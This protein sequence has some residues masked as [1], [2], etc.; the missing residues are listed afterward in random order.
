MKI[1]VFDSGLGGLFIL[2]SIIKKLPCCDYVYLGD[3]KRL[4][5]G[6]RSKETVQRFVLEAVDFLFQKD[7]ALIILACNTASAEALRRIQKEYLPKKYP[8]RRVLGVIIPTVE[9][10]IKSGALKVGVLATEGTVVSGAY[11]KEFKKRSSGR[12]LVHQKAAPLLVPLVE[13]GGTKHSDGIIEEYLIPL[14][15]KKIEALVLGC[16]HYPVLKHNIRKFFPRKAIISQDSIIADK[17]KDYLKRHPEIEKMISNRK[18]AS[19][20]VTEKTVGFE[21]TARKWFGKKIV[22]RKAVLEKS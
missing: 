5:Y 17:L 16:T 8:N 19:F 4:P 1:G 22:L 10:A 3:T 2:K 18:K 9:E 14:T 13:Y 11:V 15:N 7:C 12:V 20:F 21:K 6:S